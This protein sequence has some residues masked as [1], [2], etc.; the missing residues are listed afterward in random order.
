LL[1]VIGWKGGELLT[2]PAMDVEQTV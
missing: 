2:P 1:A